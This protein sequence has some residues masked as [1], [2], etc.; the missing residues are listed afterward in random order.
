MDLALTYAAD[1]FPGLIEELR[2]GLSVVHHP[3]VEVSISSE[4]IELSEQDLIV[5]ASRNGAKFLAGQ[6]ERF[7]TLPAAAVGDN[8]AKDLKGL[9]FDVQLVGSRADSASML[10][11]LQAG[12][13][14]RALVIHGSASTSIA[15]R[16]RTTGWKV[17]AVE[18]Y[19][20]RKVVSPELKRS[21]EAAMK[22]FVASP[23]AA[24]AMSEAGVDMTD[25]SFIAV[26][27]TTAAK[28]QELGSSTVE[29]VDVT[30]DLAAQ[31]A[32]L[33]EAQANLGP[34]G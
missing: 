33:A 4:Q 6:D 34:G 24:E 1:S 32:S 8:T 17:T 21:V 23:S 16:M 29:Q 31:L 28:L 18:G 25:I 26:G 10:E 3:A 20:N 2:E 9:G 5:V 11:E 22:T 12:N 30:G 14:K 15:D 19:E 7:R 13:G 27:P